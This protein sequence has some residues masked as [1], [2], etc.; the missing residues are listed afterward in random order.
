M[1]GCLTVLVL[2]VLM[3]VCVNIVRDESPR[4]RTPPEPEESAAAMTAKERWENKHGAFD[5]LTPVSLN[6]AANHPDYIA[7]SATCRRAIEKIP[8][9]RY[10]WTDSVFENRWKVAMVSTSNIAFGGVHLRAENGF[11]AWEKKQYYCSYDIA[12]ETAEAFFLE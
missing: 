4:T 6:I 2:F 1:K 5:S 7:A 11:G 3:S 8:R 9:Y 10:E 12:S